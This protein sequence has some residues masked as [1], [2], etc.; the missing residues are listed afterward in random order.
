MFEKKTTL[1]LD[2]NEKP[3]KDFLKH[4]AKR[5]GTTIQHTSTGHDNLPKEWC[6]QLGLE[7][8]WLQD[9]SSDSVADLTLLL[10]LSLARQIQLPTKNHKH[11]YVFSRNGLELNKKQ[12]LIIGSEGNIGKAVAKR[13]KS[14]GCK[15]MGIDLKNKQ[16]TNILFDLYLQ[17]ADIVIL[18][19]NGENNRNW[20][21]AVY[22]RTMRKRP[23]LI[24]MVRENLVNTS[25]L[26]KA[27][28]KQQISGYAVDGEIDNNFLK[29]QSCV[30]FTGHVGARTVEAQERRKKLL[31][32]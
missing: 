20:F 11:Y 16:S 14:F 26:I 4:F 27:L 18:C 10:T 5:G 19:L 28:K 6:E 13:F 8:K 2:Y 22:F 25:T 17:K 1:Y 21:K 3:I 32:R 29:E 31:K 12:V 9:Y 15:I 30:L 24:N 7:Q 23:L